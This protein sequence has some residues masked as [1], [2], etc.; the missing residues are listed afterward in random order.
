MTALGSSRRIPTVTWSVLTRS[1]RP[2]GAVFPT[3]RSSPSRSSTSRRCFVKTADGCGTLTDW[4]LNYGAW[5]TSPNYAFS[6][7][8]SALTVGGSA[9]GPHQPGR[10]PVSTMS[11]HPYIFCLRCTGRHR[12][13]KCATP[14]IVAFG[15]P[16]RHYATKLHDPCKQDHC[17]AAKDIPRR[18]RRSTK[19]C[20]C[21]NTWPPKLP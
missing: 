10:L 11:D 1:P 9:F 4:E 16:T 6:I 19:E 3:G 2:T 5:N 12:F 15:R 21:P 17:C 20:E 8:L 14:R 13:W 7:C 18:R